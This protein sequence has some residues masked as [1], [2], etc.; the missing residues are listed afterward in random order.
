MGAGSGV[1]DAGASTGPAADG[2]ASLDD[3]GPDAPSPSTFTVSG[4][5]TDAVTGDVLPNANV[6][7]LA[8]PSTCAKS[9]A[10]GDY[11]LPG[12]APTG[13]GFLV[14]FPGYVPTAWPLTPTSD[15]AY[16]A[17]LRSTPSAQGLAAQVNA[18][19][20]ASHGAILFVAVDANGNPRAGASSV[21]DLGGLL[22]YFKG[23]GSALDASL[24][25]TSSSGAGIYFQVAPGAANLT[26]TLPGTAC[27]RRGGEGWVPTKAGATV[28]VPVTAGALS[29]VRVACQ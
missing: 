19:L 9:D 6:C 25:A 29:V 2:G 12:V 17:A 4:T 27:A 8:S 24:T 13:S 10:Q 5:L 16:D 22:G 3:A 23:D 26:I 20:D 21:S 14:V 11:Q 18:T 7:L 28:L 1:V 15:V